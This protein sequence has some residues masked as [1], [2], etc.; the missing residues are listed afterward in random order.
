LRFQASIVSAHGPPQF[1]FQPLKLVNF[2]FNA[3]PDPAFHSNAD[4]DPAS[5]NNPGFYYSP[6]LLTNCCMLM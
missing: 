4:P 6:M 1:Y 5:K 3:D 2:D